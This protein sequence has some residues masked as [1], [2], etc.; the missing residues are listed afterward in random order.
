MDEAR[1]RGAVWALCGA[2]MVLGATGC[3]TETRAQDVPAVISS[4]P[5]S[6]P[7]FVHTPASRTV[8]IMGCCDSLTTGNDGTSYRNELDLLL[9]QV[10]VEPVHVVTAKP[11]SLCSTWAPKLEALIRENRPDVLLLNCGTNDAAKPQAQLGAFGRTYASMIDVARKAGVK[12]MVSKLQIS[13]V[14]TTPWQPWLP[15]NEAK[16]NE[17]IDRASKFYGDVG[18]ADF[19]AIPATAE[20]TTDGVHSTSIGEQLYAKAWFDEGVRLGWW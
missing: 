2:M 6:T 4:T 5:S 17:V 15:L 9:R 18:L 11:G 16:L 8:R 3:E 7:I 14:S 13:D 10:G 12:V 20:N 19:S 1:K